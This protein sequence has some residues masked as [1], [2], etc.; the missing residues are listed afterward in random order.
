MGIPVGIAPSLLAY[1][2]RW[3]PRNPAGTSGT[4]YLHR[5]DMR[6]NGCAFSPSKRKRWW[7]R[8]P[9]HLPISSPIGQ[10]DYGD[11]QDYRRVGDDYRGLRGITEDYRE[12]TGELQKVTGAVTTQQPPD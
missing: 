8:R 2:H 3:G 1:F 6:P 7:G 11:Q 4:C 9:R 12:I 10:G 5:R